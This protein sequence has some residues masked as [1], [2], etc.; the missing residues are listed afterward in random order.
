MIR[1]SKRVRMFNA[2][3]LRI[4]ALMG[5]ICLMLT[6]CSSSSDD[7]A[8]LASVEEGVFKDSVVS[9]LQYQTDT[10]SGTTDSGGKFK[11]RKGEKVNF[12][13]GGINFGECTGKPTVTPIDIVPGATDEKNPTVTNITRLLL[14]LDND[15]DPSNGITIPDSMKNAAINIS[16]NFNLSIADFEA[17]PIVQQT[18]LMLTGFKSGNQ[19]VL[20]AV[21]LAQTHLY[22][23]LN[24]AVTPTPTPVVTPTPTPTV[25]PMPTPTPT[26]TPTPEPTPTPTVTPTPTP[27]PTPTPTVTPEPTPTPTVTPTPTPT[28]T[29]TPTPT[30]TPV[31]SED[32]D[33]DGYTVAQNDCN[34]NNSAIHPG[35]AEICGDGIDQDCDGSDLAC[36]YP[37][38]A[39]DPNSVDSD[40][41]GYTPNQGDCNDNNAKINPKAVEICGNGIDEN[42]DGKDLPCSGDGVTLSN[43]FKITFLKSVN[44]A[45][46][47]STWKYK[48]EETA[49]SKDLGY[50]VLELPSCIT[51]VKSAT[52]SSYQLVKPDPNTGLTGIKWE[53]AADFTTGEFSFIV[54]GHWEIGTV[55]VAAKGP[56]VAKST[57]G[58]LTCKKADNDGDGYS[59]SE[60]DCN[61]NDPKI[62]PGAT[63]L[64]G[65]GIDQDCDGKDLVCTTEGTLALGDKGVEGVEYQTPTQTG[66]TD[67]KGKFKYAP[68]EKVKFF[69]GG[70]ILG[71]VSGKAIL[72]PIDL[73]PG[74]TGDT[75]AVI[76]ICALLMT[77]D[78][79]DDPENGIE[80]GETVRITAKGKSLNFTLSTDDFEIST[81]TTI[82]LLTSVKPK[83]KKLLV[84]A[85]KVKIFIQI[86][87]TFKEDGAKDEDKD[88]YTVAQG[89]CKDDDATINPKGT[90][91]CGDGKD[92][93]CNGSDLICAGDENKDEDKDGFTIGQGDCKDSD[94]KIN[95]TAAEVCGNDVD[96]NC[97]DVKEQCPIVIKN[98]AWE[99]TLKTETTAREEL[100]QPIKFNVLD[101]VISSLFA[102]LEA[103]CTGASI[104]T[105]SAK[106]TITDNKFTYT[107][108]DTEISGTFKSAE[109][110]EGK[111]FAKI[112]D[113]TVNGT[114]TAKFKAESAT[115]ETDGDKDGFTVSQGDC[116]DTNADIK[117]GAAEGC[118]STVD[119]N[120][121][122][123]KTT[124]VADADKDKVKS[125]VFLF[126][127]AKGIEYAT[128]TQA[129]LTDEKGMFK[130]MP[131]EDITFFI[132]K[133]TLGKIKAKAAITPLD[134]LSETDPKAAKVINLCRFL[135]TLD[136]D[137]DAKN[138]IVIPDALRLRAYAKD[139]IIDF[140][141]DKFE[142]DVRELVSALTALRDAGL[143]TLALAI[144]VDD[145][146]KAALDEAAKYAD[147]D[148]DTYSIIDGDC[149]D[150]DKDIYPGKGDCP[151][152]DDPTADKDKDGV[153]VGDGDCDDN[154]PAVYKG[155][156]DICGNGVD[157]DC[158][159]TDLICTV[160][161]TITSGDWTGETDQKQPISFTVKDNQVTALTIKMDYVGEFSDKCVK[162]NLLMSGDAVVE[163]KDGKFSFSKS[164][165]EIIGTFTSAT[166]ATGTWFYQNDVCEGSGKGTWTAKT[167][168]DAS[169]ADGDG[170]TKEQGDCDDTNPDVYPGASEIAG[171]GIDQ[172]CDGSDLVKDDP[173]D[174][175][176]GTWS[177]LISAENLDKAKYKAAFITIRAVAVHGEKWHGWKIIAEPKKTLK[178]FDIESKEA[179]LLLE[180]LKSGL[181][182]KYDEIR[183][184]L[185]DKPADG[186]EYANYV[187]DADGKKHQLKVHSAYHSGIKIKYKFTIV[188]GKTTKTKIVVDAAKS[189]KE[190]HNYWK[191]EPVFKVVSSEFI[192][193]T[194]TP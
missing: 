190:Q 129:G 100:T 194:T 187:V 41:D 68:G 106:I 19:R 166:E 143:G 191:L 139:V 134:L 24:P 80:I 162:S 56:D 168:A 171:D 125:G 97:D 25:T 107:E 149:D 102:Q 96:E 155:A 12:F 30:P 74:A 127:L 189:I 61:D 123:F 82:M 176:K 60:S 136:T 54:D 156:T 47:T 18:V 49:A 9:G 118:G 5:L 153:T 120:C 4:F 174:V 170:F 91:I 105:G 2:E 86:T 51:A 151:A 37:P 169:D 126:G 104:M 6:G 132:G 115:P 152:K 164:N 32:K 90:E 188:K 89:D 17:A 167:T 59:V 108:Q 7:P 36:Y 99:G 173:D 110:A 95:P 158:D 184:L 137:N 77:L 131:D 33:K 93:D 101:D 116:D 79:D 62:Y 48:V 63:E 159:G 83:G 128:A 81:Q 75:P 140:A 154:N 181:D 76:N 165:F 67:T 26:V 94:D 157:E 15:D 175:N 64:C 109:E 39:P 192:E 53:T 66:I 16:L 28:V 1:K 38:V 124:C 31:V 34:D 141:S 78:D 10:L 23:T 113:K 117:P 27:E 163:I 20:V 70:I 185:S 179:Q 3:Y 150:N 45:D 138:G 84:K 172:D 14:T 145:L 29:P 57:I 148:G 177:L 55:A 50:W 119:K 183:L 88:G 142:C 193:S 69:I 42:C 160:P 112:G 182:G 186:E 146:L 92:Q 35:Y 178:L 98:G 46:K 180:D 71:E 65:D 40:G 144:K 135:L 85:Y 121:D 44:N 147:K 52:P 130:Y 22:T 103:S 73:V 114:W 58:G 161:E 11:Y 8:P 13:L 43:G 122:G 87:I 21:V 133:I 111:W 72:T